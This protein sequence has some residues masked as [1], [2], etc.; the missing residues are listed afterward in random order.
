MLL[1]TLLQLYVADKLYTEI[2]SMK[3]AFLGIAAM[4]LLGG[5]VATPTI[6]A[7]RPYFIT[8]DSTMEEP[9]NLEIETMGLSGSPKGGNAFTSGLIEFEYG[10]KGWWTTEFYLDGQTTANESTIFT[11][12]RWENRFRMLMRE[13]IINPVFYVEFEDLNG[14]DKT[15]KEVVGYD[16]QYD[17]LVPNSIA[18][19]DR[20][21]ELETKLILS[22]N[23][24]G[25]NIAENFIA[26]KNLSNGPWEFG[27]SAAVS[28][29]LALL[30]SPDKCTLCRENFQT[31][32]EFYGGLGTTRDFLGR[33][34]SQYVGPVVGW[35]VG[36]AL[37][38]IEPT[39]GLTA[40][41]YR[42]MLR[43]GVQYEFSGVGR[44]IKKL[45]Q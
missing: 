19:R 6:A 30:A 41:S 40:A 26:E 39:F 25:W 38:K 45:F 18:S 42:V 15:L 36:N 5:F 44:K 37:F 8:Y 4:L 21:R 29:P 31:G 34:T 14:A 24:N 9:G 7:D 27:Y 20:Q 13:H 12:F 3:N 43:Y 2:G 35:Q 10:A 11:G 1:A 28:R 17:G 23:L 32:V 33:G 22:S 16:S